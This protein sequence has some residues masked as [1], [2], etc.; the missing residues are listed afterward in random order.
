MGLFDAQSQRRV[1]VPR[2]YLV[3]TP[4]HPNRL[5]C[6]QADGKKRSDQNVSA[7]MTRCKRLQIH[8]KTGNWEETMGL[9]VALILLI[10]FIV[11]VFL[12][13]LDGQA[14]LG[15]VAE[16]LLLTC[17]SVAFVIDILQRE[18]KA[19]ARDPNKE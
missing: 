16:M 8:S 18:S 1:N 11:N 17:A 9:F 15:N 4:D 13:S 19:K 5:I 6:L 10:G 7:C 12:G 14:P 3:R 2:R